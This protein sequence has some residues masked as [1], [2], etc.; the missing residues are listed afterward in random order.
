MQHNRE[1]IKAWLTYLESRPSLL[2]VRSWKSSN[3]G[4]LTFAPYVYCYRMSSLIWVPPVAPTDMPRSFAIHGVDFSLLGL[5]RG[6]CEAWCLDLYGLSSCSGCLVIQPCRPWRDF[7]TLS[8][9]CCFAFALLLNRSVFE[10]LFVCDCCSF[11][12]L[13]DCLSTFL[14]RLYLS[15][16][17][18][19]WAFL[20]GLMPPLLWSK[21]GW[22]LL[23]FAPSPMTVGDCL[24]RRVLTTVAA[25]LS[26]LVFSIA[27]E[28][29]RGLVPCDNFLF[30]KTFYC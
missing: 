3:W 16:F 20:C 29:D 21:D 17:E 6:L 18:S 19:S 12:C 26:M 2:T 24:L 10:L 13:R 1:S 23:L 14:S 7:A 28:I 11:D 5:S 22:C 15:N 8:W 4:I 9:P 25:E 27:F 30:L